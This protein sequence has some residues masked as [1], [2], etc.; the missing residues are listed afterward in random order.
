MEK[1]FYYATYRLILYIRMD[2]S[3]RV[4]LTMVMLMVEVDQYIRMEKYMKANGTW[5]KPMGMGST[6][7]KMEPRMRVTGKRIYKKAKVQRN[8]LMDRNYTI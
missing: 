2:Q 3:M 8:G 4:T 6:F 5:I 7:T 1:G